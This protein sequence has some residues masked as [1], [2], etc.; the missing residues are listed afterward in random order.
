[1]N[2]IRYNSDKEER[3]IKFDFRVPQ[4]VSII[5]GIFAVFVGV[6]YLVLIMLLASKG[7]PIV[8]LV[9]QMF[10]SLLFLVLVYGYIS[11]YVKFSEC[12]LTN[13][14][15]QGKKLQGLMVN[16]YRYR[17]D[18]IDDVVMNNLFG[19]R[20]ITIIFRQGHI[21]NDKRCKLVLNFVDNYEEVVES[22]EQ[23]ITKVKN[24]VDTLT[25]CIDGESLHDKTIASKKSV[26]K[27]EIE[28]DV[29]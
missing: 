5:I 9:A 4:V 24:D 27:A 19:A 2:N 28:F 20:R 18:C 25:L 12:R 15:I 13:K 3:L 17:L 22:L 29:E 10:S 16:H 26:K 8:S 14:K 6:I 23:L 1:M 7:F 11:L 21:N